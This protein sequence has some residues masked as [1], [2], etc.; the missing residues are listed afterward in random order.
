MTNDRERPQIPTEL[1]G[2]ID[3]HLTNLEKCVARMREALDEREAKNFV[4]NFSAMQL[5]ERSIL[6][7]CQQIMQRCKF[8][9]KDLMMKP[10]DEYR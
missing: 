4:D 6:A 3:E 10:L 8:N 9:E 5:Q 7:G 1:Q 2:Y